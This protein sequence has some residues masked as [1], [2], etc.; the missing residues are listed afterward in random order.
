[1]KDKILATLVLCFASGY[2]MAGENMGDVQFLGVV[3]DETCNIQP[4]VGGATTSL[5][6]LGSVKTSTTAGGDGSNEGTPV[7]F[8]LKPTAACAETM[9]SA[10]FGFSS[11]S[12]NSLGV[13]N[14][15]GTATDANMIL[16]AINATGGPVEIKQGSTTVEVPITDLNTTGAEFTAQLM[17]GTIAG[18][19]NSTVVYTVYYN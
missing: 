11:S 7:A 12:L 6:R 14:S 19:Y 3:S 18:E 8:S 16:T 13:G 1:M 5:V 9:S 2:V 4:D 17:G 15:S 10:V